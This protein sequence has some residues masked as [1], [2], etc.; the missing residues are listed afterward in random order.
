MSDY[1]MSSVERFLGEIASPMRRGQAR[2]ALAVLMRVEGEVAARSAHVE[3]WM[4]SGATADVA[5]SRI[6]LPD[7]TRYYAEDGLTLS[8]VQY[9]SFLEHESTSH[10]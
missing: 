7:D 3:R 8:A 10:A 9:A 6:V 4:S 5:R 1:E 2:K